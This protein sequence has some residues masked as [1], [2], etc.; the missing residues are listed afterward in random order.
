[1]QPSAA[2]DVNYLPNKHLLNIRILSNFIKVQYNDFTRECADVS[3]L[4]EFD[5]LWRPGGRENG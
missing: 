2:S 5:W 3:K 1:M 4:G